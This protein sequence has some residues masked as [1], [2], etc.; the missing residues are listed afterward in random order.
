[1]KPAK[2]KLSNL[3][4]KQ[5][6]LYVLI[7][8]FVTVLIWISGSLF[9]SQR[10]SGISPDLL[11]LATPLSPTINIE[12]INRIE[13]SSNYSDQ[14]LASFQIYKIIKSKDG[15]IQQVVP[16][17]SNQNEIS[18]EE[19]QIITRQEKTTQNIAPRSN[20]ESQ[21]DSGNGTFDLEGQDLDTTTSPTPLASPRPRGVEGFGDDG[22]F[23]LD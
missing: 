12:L 9:K 21:I 6:A 2:K 15:R 13:Q 8:S 22:R 17:E 7:F 11:E 16:I 4:I 18:E 5:Q 14:E 19:I 3:K 10:K 20:L 23:Y 1:M